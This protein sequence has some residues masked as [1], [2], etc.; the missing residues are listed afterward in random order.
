MGVAQG[1]KTRVCTGSNRGILSG[2]NHQDPQESRPA[3][4][5]T[6]VHAAR[7]FDA[8]RCPL[9]AI[10]LLL[11][12]TGAHAAVDAWPADRG[13]DQREDPPAKGS[14][15]VAQSQGESP[16]HVGAA[17]GSTCPLLPSGAISLCAHVPATGIAN[18]VRVTG[19]SPFAAGCTPSGG[20]VP[21]HNAEVE[22]YVAINPL[23]PSNL[24]GVWQQDRWSNGGASGLATG[25]SSDGGRNWATTSVPFSICAGGNAGNGGDFQR[26]SDPWVT[27]GPDGIAYQ[28]AIGFSG[29][30]LQPGS[31][32][33]VLA[34]RSTDG[35]RTWSAPFAIIRDGGDAFNDKESITADPYAA[36]FVYA[37][38]DRLTTDDRGPSWFARSVDAGVSWQP[39]RA[40]YDPGSERQ[41]INN[42]VVV[43]ADGTLIL[44]FTELDSRQQGAAPPKL[45]IMRSQDRGATWS[46]PIVIGT[47]QSVGT[48]DPETGA[49]V[50][51][52]NMLGA[53]AAGRNGQ[54]AVVWQDARFG[55]A[56][57]DGI[58]FAR[59]LDG[60]LTWSAPVG[61]NA[62]RTAPAFVPAVQIRDD[63]MIG[64]TYYDM[65]N[66]TADASTLPVDYWL[67]QSADGR[68]WSERRVAG[69]FDLAQAPVANG[70]FLGDYQALASIGSVFVPFFVQTN[71]ASPGN[72]TDVFVFFVPDDAGTLHVEA[73]GDRVTAR[74][75][76]AIE[77]TPELA[78]RVRAT[79]RRAI[80]ARLN[81]VL[82]FPPAQIE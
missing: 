47:V 41:T 51:D 23:D 3:G 22:P 55:G 24:V 16:F 82:P 68:T 60:G 49:R 35:G 72:R 13:A 32:G 73:Q 26:A 25:F 12:A 31:S 46:S 57:H 64:V 80:A 34:S 42:I 62:V 10:V 1:L 14:D 76:D 66:N 17:S 74:E 40:V 30:T 67:T 27:F 39:P 38:W 44:S 69:P 58:A 29:A 75:S 2:T 20:G 43:L 15:R 78:E 5:P 59:S 48:R 4:S 28:I 21:Y 71:T 8:L 70:L 37:A 18:P 9:A 45:A 52:G 33:A 63:G 61:V 56:S 65:R 53:I 19:A 77:W 81:R 50:R 36:G 11:G 7:I 79:V 54:L 6:L